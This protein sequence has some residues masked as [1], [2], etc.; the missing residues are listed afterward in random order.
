MEMIYAVISNR[1]EK[2]YK[3][4]TL[5]EAKEF[6]LFPFD[7]IVPFFDKRYCE[8]EVGKLDKIGYREFKIQ[9]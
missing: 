8:L 1:E 7:T 3:V 5:V 9:N 4:I 2:I 6:N